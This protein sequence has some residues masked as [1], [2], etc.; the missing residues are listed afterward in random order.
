MIKL[1]GTKIEPT[2]FPDRTS[3][4][5]QLPDKLFQ[6][7]SPI[8]DWNFDIE[9]ELI[10]LAQLKDLL[11][12]KGLPCDLRISYLPY[13]RQD[14]DISNNSTFALHT[15]AKILNLLNFRHISILDPHSIKA[16]ELINNS[17]A[18]YPTS[19]VLYLSK[20]FLTDV[21][22][23]P[24]KGASSKY[25]KMYDLPAVYGEKIRNSLSGRIE[26]YSLHGDVMNKSVLVV[27]DICDGGATFLL[28]ANSLQEAGAKSIQ[29]YVSHGIFSKGVEIL[30]AAGI[31]RI[32]C[33]RG[34][35]ITYQGDI[36]FKNV[37]K[38]ATTNIVG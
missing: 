35:V 22:V 1:N 2:M 29:M 36:A 7:S 17:E 21:L 5:W 12:S 18:L 3:Q 32:F 11:D 8:I 14:K 26:K 10:T 20:L 6:F 37:F 16:L 34:E 23:Y 19:D 24:D 28:L 25:S 13:G 27:D 9:A 15:F 31:N 33:S 38:Q 30:H 4:V